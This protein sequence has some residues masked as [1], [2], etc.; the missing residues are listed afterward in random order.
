MTLTA[1][2]PITLGGIIT[3]TMAYIQMYLKNTQ[4]R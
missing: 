4:A 3:Y 2:G 1:A